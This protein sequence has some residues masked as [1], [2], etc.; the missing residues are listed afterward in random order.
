LLELLFEVGFHIVELQRLH[1]D[2]R[3]EIHPVSLA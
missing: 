1:C 3:G 2:L